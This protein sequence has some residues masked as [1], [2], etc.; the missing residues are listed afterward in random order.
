MSTENPDYL[1]EADTTEE[2]IRDRLLS[3][4]TDGVDKSQ[5]SYVWDAHAPVAIELVFVAMALQKALKLGFAETTDIDHLVMRASEHG[6]QRKEA[7]YATGTIHIVGTPGTIIP[8]GFRLAT[9]A[10][11]DIG[12]ESVFFETTA[13][14]TL[15]AEGAADIPIKATEAGKAGNV[16]AGSIVVLAQSRDG[17]TSVTNPTATTGGTEEEDY[18]SLL[19]RYLTKVR[20]PGTSGNADDYQQWALSVPGV[21]GAHVKP[22]W[23]GEG[24][25]KVIIIDENKEPANA[26]LVAAVQNYLMVDAGSGD[27]KAPIGATVTVAPATIVTIDVE[28]TVILGKGEALATVQE[29]FEAALETYLRRIAFQVGTIR[30]ARIG[31]TL[32]DIDGVVDYSSLKV[33]GEEDNISVGNEDVAILGTV[34][35]HAE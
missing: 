14:V 26:D 5:G 29:A 32:L 18:E 3:N 6:V 15:P 12:V 10:D 20:N 9:E 30:Y 25:V 1:K 7:T 33:N 2:A 21:G 27:R 24:T 28:A 13:E 23:A 19:S 16:A 4:V 35:L 11:A 34:T 22:L 31:A 17:V 8:L